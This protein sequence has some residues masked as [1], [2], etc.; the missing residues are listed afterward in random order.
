MDDVMR[1]LCARR[2]GY[3]F[4]ADLIE[5]GGSDADLRAAKRSGLLVRLRHGTFALGET[6][7]GMSPEQKH[8]LVARSVLARLGPG[9]VLSHHSA[10]LAHTPHSFDIDLD[11]VHVTRLDGTHGRKEAGVVYHVGAI[12]EVDVVEKDGLRITAPARAAFESAT[13]SST[14]SGLVI[15]NA[16]VRDADCHEELTEVVERLER[17][18]G[19]RHARLALRL[20]DPGCESVGESRSMFMFWKEG[21][22]RPETQVRVFDVDG[23]A[24]ARTDFTWRKVCHVGEFDGLVKYGR[25][26]PYEGSDAGSVLVDEKRRE[27]QIRGAGFGVSRWTWVDLEPKRRGTTAARILSD[28]ERSSRTFAVA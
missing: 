26:N 10:A 18:P 5:A 1:M 6:V 4:R 14:E 9:V 22:P 15:M 3:M 19:G 24:V 28:L 7:R 12:T 16:I 23:T 11:S 8:V 2:G 20:V 27:D 21:V 25:L 17:W 13:I